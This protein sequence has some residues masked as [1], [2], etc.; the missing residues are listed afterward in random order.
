M[1]LSR[2][3]TWFTGLPEPL[4]RIVDPRIHR[5][6]PRAA[7]TPPVSQHSAPHAG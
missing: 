1:I 5:H 2:S 3:L 6:L 7:T 4:G